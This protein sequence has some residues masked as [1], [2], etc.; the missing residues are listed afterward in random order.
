LDY[1][2]LYS[3]EKEEKKMT[4][5]TTGKIDDQLLNNLMELFKDVEIH[6]CTHA[7]RKLDDEISLMPIFRSI[8]SIEN[9][10]QRE[11]F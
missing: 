3:A 1:H 7:K 10:G 9:E 11:L 4:E 8:N 2:S 6:N 5:E